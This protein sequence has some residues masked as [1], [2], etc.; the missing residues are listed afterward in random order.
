MPGGNQQIL[1]SVE[2][3]VLEQD[4][5]GPVGGSDSGVPGDVAVGVIAEVFEQGV[6]HQLRPVIGD[7]DLVRARGL[8]GFLSQAEP[9]IAAEHVEHEEVGIAVAVVIGD[10]HAHGTG[11]GG[12]EGESL[13]GAEASAALVDPEAVG[14]PVVVADVDV[15]QQIIVEVA[16]GGGQAPVAGWVDE[17]RS[18]FVEEGAIGPID[19][20]EPSVTV[21]EQELIRLAVFVEHAV[22]QL[23]AAAV[24]GGGLNSSADDPQGDFA[25]VPDVG[26]SVIGDVEVQGAIAVHIGQRERGGAGRA[27]GAG[28]AG[29]IL[30]AA[31][32]Q[33]EERA[34]AL[35]QGADQEILPAVAVDVGEDRAAGKDTG[36]IDAR[37]AGHLLESPPAQ[38]SVE[39]VGP[40]QPAEKEVRPAV[41]VEIAHCHTRTVVEHPVHGA[42]PFGEMVGEQD[43]TFGAGQPGETDLPG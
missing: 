11:A 5:P 8:G 12:A 22:D 43:P 42:V 13:D 40:I 38:V 20:S 33:V 34:D 23:E 1:E 4:R 6:A 9:G 3:D 30:E 35:G 19:G 18:G 17:C 37:L 39:G 15:R 27:G 41:P 36:H 29:T 10:V 31:V 14:G 16:E 7:A 28:L 26:W 32:A 24:F 21:V 25:L 2:V